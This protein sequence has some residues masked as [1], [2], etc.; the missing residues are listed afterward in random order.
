MAFEDMNDIEPA[1]EEAGPP[2]EESS[3][4][5]FLIVAGVLAGVLVLSLLCLAAYAFFR[6]PMLQTQ[7]ATEEAEIILQNELMEVSVRQTA[8][9]K[10]IQAAPPTATP[11]LK[12]TDTPVPPTATRVVAQ[13]AT[14]TPTTGPDPRTATVAALLT[15][16]AA[17]QTATPQATATELPQSGFADDVGAPGL[18]AL[19]A[20]LV[21]VIFAARRLRTA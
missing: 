10:E 20:L 9:A 6:V 12:P 1:V 17:A 5:P 13:A 2:P 21:G 15:Q 14:R 3:N 8:D 16:A 18:L 4:R 19:A 11:T 7:R